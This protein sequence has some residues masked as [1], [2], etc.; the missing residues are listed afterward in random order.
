[1]NN[2]EYLMSD[3]S[4][5]EGIGIKT[6]KLFKKKN[7][8]TIF[9][10]LL[11]LPKSTVDRTNESK[12]KDLRIGKIQ[13]LSVKVVKYNFPRLRNLPNKVICKDETGELECV[14][15]NSYE[16]Y[17]KKILPLNSFVN[18]S[19]KIN[20][21]KNKY[22]I[23]N[24]KY[25]STD[26]TIIKKIHPK[27]G[28]TDGLNE[29][30]YNQILEK[31]LK[32]LPDL[33]EWHNNNIKKLFENISWKQAILKLHDPKNFKK[34]DKFLNRLIF[35]EILA[36]FLINSK[37]RTKIKK[38][39]KKQKIFSNNNLTK[40]TKK[41]KFNLTNDQVKALN[42]INEDLKSKNKMFRLLQGDVGSG[43]TIV[44]LISSL[45]VIDSGYQVAFMAPTEILTRQH[46][47]LAK[48]LFEKEINI[49]ML[50]GKNNYKDKNN[51]ISNLK[52]NKT[53]IIFGT[54]SLFQEKVDF[55]N[56][57]LIIIDEQH[58][59]GVKQR[60]YLS[61]KGGKECD[62]LVMSATPIPR[63]MIMTV[64][65]DMD[66]SLIKEKPINRKEV[67]T[68]SLNENKL[69]D[70]IEFIKKEIQKENQIFWVCPLI[71]ESKKVD[72]QSSVN[73]FNYLKKIFKNK[74]GLLHGSLDNE[75]KSIILNKFLN[76]KINILVSTTVIE[77][78]IDFP[79]ANVIIIENAN[80]FG[81][82]QLHQLRGRVGRG[83][84]ESTCILLFKSNLSNNAKKRIQILKKSNNGFE[85]AEEDMKLRGFGDL[86]GFKQS[87][88]NHFRL[89]DPI[90]NEEL[91]LLAE[92]EV[93]KIENDENIFSKYKTLLKLYDRADIL[94]DIV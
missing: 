16:G 47:E 29:K 68:Y 69:N 74:I 2:Y 1:M 88:V 85:I 93:K 41:I 90:N 27:Y 20:I 22:Q 84:K 65:G 80:K 70:V 6:S 75:N 78:G 5:I 14:F 67:K 62:I 33:E 10:L 58:K 36:T 48:K 55:H 61:D 8:H 32:N 23:T 11:T 25:I 57:G 26:K 35:D 30:K 43:K 37:L 17:I 91:F 49:S 77:V 63:T 83:E 15:F 40:I 12:V 21:Y 19:G 81:L 18:I 89:A 76:K 51:I 3:L 82:S 38:I 56:L 31:V 50:T 79:N 86:L 9:D 24:P 54:H 44:S 34:K 52:N 45:N 42:E 60:K 7:I 87:G 46:F 4:I 66:T 71:E 92:K 72:H 59:F 53:N 64:Y 28:L 39:K 94:N 13:T 73:R